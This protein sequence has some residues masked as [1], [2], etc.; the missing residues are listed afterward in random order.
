MNA[1]PQKPRLLLVDDEA[2]LRE[3]TRI[4]LGREGFDVVTAASGEEALVKLEGEGTFDLILTDLRMTG[5]TGLD[6]LSAAKRRDPSTQVIM[7]TAYASSETAVAAMK[8]GAYDY[9]EKPFKREALVVLLLKALEKRQLMQENFI[10]KREAASRTSFG[11][12]VGK[13]PKMKGLFSLLER[14][15]GARTTILIQGESGTGKELVARAIHENSP[16]ADRPFIAVN[17]GA[18]PEQLLEGEFFGHMKGAFTGAHR[19]RVGLFMAA[20]G[21]TIFLDEVGELPLQMQVKL[22]RV[23]QER[24][25]QP[26]GSVVETVVDVR[27]VAATNK[28][29]FEEVQTKRFREDLYYRLNVI[30]L[31]VP[32]LRERS[33]DI[34]LLIQHFLG[35]FSQEQD[36]RIEGVSPRAMEVLLNYSY[37]GNV[38][39]L[40]N[41]IE[42]AV[43]LELDT[44]ISTEVLPTPMMR[45][46]QF[47][48]LASDLELPEEGLELEQMVENLERSLLLQAIERSQGNRTEAAK[49]LGI[50]FRSIRY[51]LDKYGISA[52]ES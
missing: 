12:M 10:L 11:R 46:E 15:A 3:M 16:R 24:K 22:L 45:K 23:L 31:E 19:D 9:I 49:L 47:L 37:P 26:V 41:I 30:Q 34:P 7:M 5:L 25:I 38:R 50:S 1:E 13:S 40:E 2:S 6:V 14:V 8:S 17:C 35:R 28:D 32:P 29:L 51:R 39:E 36:K 52:D 33:E 42:R 48:R 44:L 43:T 20:D 21:G 27:V 4:L 18:I